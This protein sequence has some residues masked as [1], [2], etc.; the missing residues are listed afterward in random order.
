MEKKAVNKRKKKV[1]VGWKKEKNGFKYYFKESVAKRFNIK[2]INFPGFK[3]QP[4]GLF[5]YHTGGGFNLRQSN[6][7]GGSYFLD[8]LKNKYKKPIKLAVFKNGHGAGSFKIQK[9]SIALSVSFEN[10]QEILKDLGSEIQKNKEFV[11]LVRLADFF[12][13][14]FKVSS[15]TA[16]SKLSEI[17][18]NTLDS[19]GREAVNHFIKRYLSL[20]TYDDKTLED[21]Q[22]L[23]IQGRKKTLDQVIKKFERYIKS[24]KYS[25]KRWQKFLHEEVFFFISNY[26]ESIREADVNFGKNEEGAK[27]PDFVWIDIYGFLDVFEIKTPYTDILARRLD[28]GHDNYY[29]S[30]DASRAISQIEKY[31]LFLEKNVEGFEK[32]LS[33]QTKIPFSVLKPKAFLIIGK[34][35]ELEKNEAKKRDFRL[36]RRSFKNIEFMTFDELLDN[37]KNLARKFEESTD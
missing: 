23:V 2:T 12:P 34:S 27:K 11:I 24:K 5:L 31:I 13:K 37:L 20:S 1:P 14:E 4:I 18:L 30:S 29:F 19:V 7:I 9:K 25:E 17:N 15:Q 16:G 8:F 36:L 6:K 35:K 32:Y 21:L 26:V 33:K 22:S 10:F 3:T 28:K